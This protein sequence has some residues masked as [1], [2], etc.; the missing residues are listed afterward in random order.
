MQHLSSSATH[1]LCPRSTANQSILVP[2]DLQKVIE[3]DNAIGKQNIPIFDLSMFGKIS[4]TFGSVLWTDWPLN[5]S[6][7]TNIIVGL[8]S[9]FELN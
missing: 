6:S 2:C 9:S 8:M 4:M 3:Y 7:F 5:L 1:S